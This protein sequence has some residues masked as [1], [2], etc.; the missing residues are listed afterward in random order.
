MIYLHKTTHT[1]NKMVIGINRTSVT[2]I[3]MK[4]FWFNAA[5]VAD[6]GTVIVTVLV[7]VDSVVVTVLVE[8]VSDTI[9]TVVTVVGAV[10]ELL[11]PVLVLV[12]MMG[13][14]IQQICS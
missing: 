2:A 5:P 11:V 9:V 4:S 13:S 12:G 6:V 3:M 14:V 10:L 1:V 7:V 8:D